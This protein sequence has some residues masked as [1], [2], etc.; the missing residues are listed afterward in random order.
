[1]IKKVLPFIAIS[2]FSL[3]FY[4]C[5]G[6]KDIAKNEN[7]G[8]SDS[9]VQKVGIVSEMLEQARQY[10]VDALTKQEQ[11][12]VSEAVNNYE[13][14]LRIINNLSYY[15]GI[16]Q[17]EAYVDLEK[18]VIN[19]YKKYVDSLPELPSNV[20]FA[21]LEEWMGKSLPEIK[22]G[23]A[24]KQKDNQKVVVHS[25]IPLEVNSY[26]NQWLDYFTGKG[27][28]H[29]Q[30]WLERSGR[31]FPMMTKIFEKEGVPKQL[32]YLSM[33]E[34]GLNPLARSWA[35]AVGLWQFIR[36]T[37]RLYGLHS[38][39]YIDERRD[40]EKAT[41]AAARHLKDL[42]NDLGDWYL[43]LAAYNAGEGRITRAI[44]RAGESDFWAAR[45]YLPRETRSY[46]PQYIAVTLIAMNPAKYGFTDIN[47]DKPFDYTTYNVK[48]SIDLNFLAQCA[49]IDTQTLEEMNPELTQMC[50]PASYP[51]G[52]PLKIP[53][54]SL[55]T[56]AANVVNVPKSARRNYAVH[57]VRRG[58]TLWGIASRFG[59]SLH[60]L[61]NVNNISVRSRIYPGVRLK[62]P[63]AVSAS[64]DNV[65]YNTDTQ[66]AEDNQNTQNNNPGDINNPG[67]YVSPYLTLN[68]D[69]SS[70]SSGSLGDENLVAG[71]EDNGAD[72]SAEDDSAGED[73]ATTEVPTVVPKGLVAVQYKVKKNDNLLGIA[74]LF[75]SRV[76]DIRNWNNIPYTKSIVVGQELTIYVPADK[77]EF[78]ASLDN[79][80][81]LEKTSS[82]STVSQ[83]SGSKW[84]YHRI[85][86]GENLI[87]IAARYGVSVNSIKDW[88]NISG[89]RIYVGKRLKI[90]AD[91]NS[92]YIA[93]SENSS[94][95][96]KRTSVFR[97]RIKRGDNLSELSVKF[98]VPAET[99]KRWNN[100]RSNRLV[101]G[102]TIKIYSNN[103]TESLGDNSPKTSANINYYKV[104]PHDTIGEIAELYKVRA[105]S[106]RRWNNLRSNK[107]IVGQTLKVYSDADIN[108]ISN[109]N[110]ASTTDNADGSKTYTV[111][112]GDTIIDIAAKFNVSV[113]DIKKWN[114]LNSSR[115]IAG[116]SL[117]I[118]PASEVENSVPDKAK[119][120]KT[121]AGGNVKIHTVIR[122][123]SLYS[124]ARDNKMSVS[125]LKELNGLQTNRIKI[126]DK[127]KVE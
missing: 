8:N 113:E 66:T 37:G 107:I 43:V 60:D 105:S 10:Y 54:T 25:E 4:S 39:F 110:K 97:Y 34:S 121:S 98:G 80:T 87:S 35:S 33:V 24:D 77:Q 28:E 68:N 18:S 112:K 36:S 55:Q 89:N 49:G 9:K 32:E 1:M 19:D 6:N 45:D 53:K 21:A 117:K 104:K 94:G 61:A 30:V 51:S 116:N 11:N 42:Y 79:Q 120:I 108:D 41:I 119:G 46:V 88:N 122:G 57:T 75:N 13:S 29:M 23:M 86:R 64:Y 65:A 44:R 115:I 50:T 84:I 59:V 92:R 74:D 100:I 101:A 2:L 109:T 67:G 93:S 26:V 7:S 52:Y 14:A 96:S 20:S 69:S 48:G 95:Y 78:Y 73:I 83:N 72:V 125:R 63:L 40:P 58:E 17:N 103:N 118:N 99:I 3:L 85:H 76:I 62:I 5:G 81:T 111:R 12:S 91:R 126:G 31:Y 82:R 16:E 90:Y 15:P 71:N 124:I 106:I 22:S 114:N 47:Y 56:F 127:L 38:D 70:D 123:E 102:H 27:R